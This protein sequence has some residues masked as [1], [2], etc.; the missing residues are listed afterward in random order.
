MCVCVCV[1]VGVGVGVCLCVCVMQQMC[2]CFME[3][4]YHKMLHR[5]IRSYLLIIS[6]PLPLKSWMIIAIKCTYTTT[7]I[8][9]R[10]NMQTLVR[11]WRQDDRK[12]NIIYKCGVRT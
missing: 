6:N 9:R 3:A 8:Y 4:D 2:V 12:E 7:G 1:G 5:C 11:Q 10:E